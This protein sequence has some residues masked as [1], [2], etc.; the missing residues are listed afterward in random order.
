VVDQDSTSSVRIVGTD[1]YQ[2]PIQAGTG[3]VVTAL[4]STTPIDAGFTGVYTSPL[5]P[6]TISPRLSNIAACFEY[7]AFRDVQIMYIPNCGSATAVSVALGY[8]ADVDALP[9]TTPG[10]TQQ[11]VLESPFCVM[12]PAW[13]SS[14][15]RMKHTGTKLYQCDANQLESY[16][17]AQGAFQC[18]LNGASANVLYGQ[19]YISY[20]LD[21]YLPVAVAEYP[22]RLASLRRLPRPRDGKSETKFL[23][24]HPALT[25]VGPAQLVRS[26]PPS[27]DDE[28]EVVYARELR[29]TSSSSAAG[30]VLSA[31]PLSSLP[32]PLPS[33]AV[34]V[35][36]RK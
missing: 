20:T 15:F 30:L 35:S 4:P 13:Q 29:R 23:D 22:A 3:A 32:P 34:K 33:P 14:T 7:Y 16:D 18:V 9:L 1:L 11:T 36:S 5:S 2:Y 19:L 26:S 28:E 10:F 27:L 31:P 24:A 25:L 21:L 8:V 12:T 17:T 6:S